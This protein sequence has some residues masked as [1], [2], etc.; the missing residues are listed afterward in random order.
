MSIANEFPNRHL[1]SH[2]KRFS[3]H[4]KAHKLIAHLE[5]LTEAQRPPA[6]GDMQRFS[7]VALHAT[8]W[9]GRL[10]KCRAS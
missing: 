6:A 3:R 1:R 8:R 4:A 10:L 9:F 7:L 2:D 5:D